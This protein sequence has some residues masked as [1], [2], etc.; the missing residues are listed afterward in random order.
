MTKTQSTGCTS[1]RS[2]VRSKRNQLIALEQ[3]GIRELSRPHR[4]R[5]DQQGRAELRPL[6]PAARQPRGV[7]RHRDRRHQRQPGHRPAPP[8]RVQDDERDIQLYINSPGGS[9]TAG[10]GIYDTMQFIAPDVSTICVGQAASWAAVLLAAGAP[11]KRLALPNARVLIHQ[12][13]GGAQGQTTRPGDPGRGDAPGPPPHRGAAGPAHR[14]GP[15]PG[16]R[17]HRAGLHRPGRRGGRV[18]TGRRGHRPPQRIA[19]HQRPGYRAPELT[20]IAPTSTADEDPVDAEG[21]A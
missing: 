14:P 12:P 17:R 4:H 5:A 6:L 10:F 9:V 8:P 13:H 15:G 2:T 16:G 11:G 18:R 3:G 1:A 20:P 19:D 7:P 21:A